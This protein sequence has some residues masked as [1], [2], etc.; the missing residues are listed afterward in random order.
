MADGDTFEEQTSAIQTFCMVCI[1][2]FLISARAEC[3]HSWSHLLFF[4][5]D[6]EP[7]GKKEAP[8]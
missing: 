3:A 8:Q 1:Q 4:F 6:D 2:T 7:A 5:S